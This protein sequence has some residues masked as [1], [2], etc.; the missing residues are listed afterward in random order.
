[1]KTLFTTFIIAAFLLG[2]CNNS[3]AAGRQVIEVSQETKLP[4]EMIGGHLFSQWTINDTIVASVFLETGFPRIVINESFAEK[5]LQNLVTMVENTENTSV[6][7]WG[8]PGERTRVSYFINDSLIV[9]GEKIEINA[10][11]TDFPAI[12]E[13]D[14]LFPLYDLGGKIKLN[15]EDGY[16]QIIRE[17][18][19]STSDFI[20]FDA[21]FDSGTRGLY[22]TT[23]LQVYDALGEKE[24]LSGNFLFDIGAANAFFLNRNIPETS[25]FVAQSERMHLTEG[26]TPNPAAE[27]AVIMP[28]RIIIDK[29]EIFNTFVPAMNMYSP[30]GR[31]NH[32]VG[33]IGNRFLANFI[34]IFDFINSKVYLKPNSDSVK[35]IE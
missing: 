34:V 32:F 21:N 9:N 7:S 30:S 6:A 11:V 3:Q 17:G 1:M 27:L 4:L 16:M 26:F 31:A 24:E 35:I 10:F 28:R 29:I 19:F 33:V 8:R 22:I 13:R 25:T 15:I 18:E 12:R 20:V 23:T 5:H 2:S 14:M